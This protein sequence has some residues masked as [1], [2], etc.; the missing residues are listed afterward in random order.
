MPSNLSL[1]RRTRTWCPFDRMD[2]QNNQPKFLLGVVKFYLIKDGYGF[3][4]PD[5]NDD[6][7]KDRFFH[8]SQLNV[9]KMQGNMERKFKAISQ[10]T[11]VSFIPVVNDKGLA[12]MNVTPI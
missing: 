8:H 10:G 7:S 2:Q 3:I 1:P 4:I 5:G 11:R 12:A 6:P 9:P